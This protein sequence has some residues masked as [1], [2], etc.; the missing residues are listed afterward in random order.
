M[1]E[2]LIR[3]WAD[4]RSFERGQAYFAQ[5]RVRRLAADGVA[6]TATVDGTRTYRVRLRVTAAGLDGECSCPYGADGMFCK[7]CVATGLAWLGKGHVIDTPPDAPEKITDE[8]LRGFL[9]RRDPGWLAAELLRAAEADPLLR[10][11]LEV[12]AGADVR[13]AFDDRDLRERLEDAIEIDD[14]VSY[15]EAYSH[16]NRVEDVLHGV[17]ELIVEGFTDTAIEL[18]EYA[19]ELIE[20]SAGYV[21][22]SNGEVGGAL[23][24][25][26]RIHLDACTAG[27][28]D[29]VALADRLVDRALSSDYE[30]FLDALPGYAEVLGESGMAR[31]RERVEAAWRALPP[32]RPGVYGDGR[33]AVTYLMERLAE[34]EGGTDALIEV[35]AR[36]VTSGYDVL[37]IA[38]KLAG[39][40]R[41]EEALAW[42]QRGLDDFDGGDQLRDLGAECLLRLG[43]REEAVRLRWANFEENPSL[44]DYQALRAAAAEDFP[45]W[46]ERALTLLGVQPAMVEHHVGVR[47][48][49]SAGHSVLVEIL[50]WEG[51]ADGAW[52]A[53]QRGGC[54]QD[55]WLRVA[56]ARATTH[57]A[58]AL[59][60][61]RRAAERLIEEKNRSSYQQAAELLAESEALSDRCGRSEDFRA[62]LVGLRAAHKPKRA[63]R[64][65]LDRARLPG[66]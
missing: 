52:Q 54:H 13:Y 49:Q 43:R 12:A 26:Q 61:L 64:E 51:D 15:G 28:P 55:L 39:D 35:L 57:P 27:R 14:Y 60:V 38:H 29:P 31:Y 41:D 11:R 37:R 6:V 7:H 4:G 32:R 30:V 24:T 20:A 36:D 45:A 44:A 1:T 22:D 58:D 10:A 46:R 62:Y 33:F 66:G 9:E 21:D 19:M 18:T 59:P 56:R 42:I 65:E 5:G 50:M 16:F 40:G 25:A 2:D 63:L 23:A 3:R 8:A 34:C 47:Y 17:T 48:L 53:A